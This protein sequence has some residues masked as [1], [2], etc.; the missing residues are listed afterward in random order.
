MSKPTESQQEQ[1]RITG[2][3][4]GSG[5]KNYSRKNSGGVWITWKKISVFLSQVPFGWFIACL[6]KPWGGEWGVRVRGGGEGEG[7]GG[8][9]VRRE[10]ER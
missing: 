10:G 3:T 2:S 5:K 9:G 7:E 6:W 1:L 8:G 4:H